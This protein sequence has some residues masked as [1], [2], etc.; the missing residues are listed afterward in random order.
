MGEEVKLAYLKGVV[1]AALWL[2]G[3]ALASEPAAAE[4]PPLA[5]YAAL[6]VLDRVTVS[7]SGE[8][9]AYELTQH[10]RR[11]LVARPIDGR[12]LT[13]QAID[14]VKLRDISWV[15]DHHLILSISDTVHVGI[16]VGGRHELMQHLAIDLRDGSTRSLLNHSQVMNASFGE[17]GYVQ[18]DGAWYG[19]FS[20]IP[21]TRSRV[22]HDAYLLPGSLHLVEVRLD[23]GEL[24]TV[25]RGNAG[26]DGWVLDD[27]G[28]VLANADYDSATNVWRLFV[29]RE[30]RRPLV[31]LRDQVPEPYL[32]GHGYTP[33]SVLV[34]QTLADGSSRL[35]EVDL[36]GDGSLRP[37]MADIGVHALIYT[38]PGGKLI[39]VQRESDRRERLY[40]DPR[41]Q[42][43]ADAAVRAFPDR[44]VGI[45][46]HDEA[47]DHLVVYTDGDGDAGT[48]W[49]VDIDAGSAEPLGSAYPD[50]P[51]DWVG[52]VRMFDYR[53]GDGLAMR[54]VLTLPPHRE[55]RDLP[56]IAMP[57]GGPEARDYP[58][59][60]WI[61]QA[62]AS[63]GY[64]V[65]QPNFRGSSGYGAAFFN[66]GLGEWGGRMQTDISD[67]IAA[68]AE[69]G[70][71]DA[72]R[73]CIV[74]GSYGGYAALAGVTMQQGVYRC[75]VSIAGISDLRSFMSYARQRYGM[76]VLR[77]FNAFIGAE[78]KLFDRTARERSPVRH[79]KQADAPVLLIHGRDDLVVPL[80]QSR[81]MARAL[82][83]AKK[84]V[85]L[86]VLDGEDHWLSRAPT[87][88]Q[89]L[90]Q[91]LEFVQ[92]YLP[93]VQN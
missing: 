55:P 5:A 40:F 30:R 4:P 18:R 60:N 63:R 57:H 67:G 44:N 43:R 32:V 91:A 12:P 45:R 68:L 88:L 24:R 39:G 66:A 54:G 14:D 80:S 52:P 27:D 33:G 89:T 28:Q 76:N 61:A 35:A 70:I 83:R 79:A 46:S 58:E 6:P 20:A 31:E 13:V 49:W 92:R 74:G 75:A 8:R 64:A 50:V 48:W 81:A 42:A 10:G 41:L 7:P 23:T 3:A 26:N 77:Y 93:A 82:R 1:A 16:V 86:V 59:F 22:T 85:E 11:Y 29:G 15:G 53:A 37:V 17:H 62:F 69:K 73:A 56:V 87:R 65:W 72:D 34:A 9:L 84:P 78:G 38:R 21:V 36:D 19:Y 25:V 2:A 71:V 51:S 90:E 47:M